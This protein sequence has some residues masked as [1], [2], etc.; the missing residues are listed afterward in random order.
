MG[1]STTGFEGILVFNSDDFIINLGIQ[2]VRYKACADALN[3]MR[4]GNALR[5]YRRTCRLYSN[6]LHIGILGFQISAYTRKSTAGTYAGNKDINLAFGILP[7]FRTGRCSVGG[8][9]SRIGK[10]AGDKAVRSA[11]CQLLSFGNRTFHTL[12]TVSQ[13]QL[14]AI[15]L[16]QIAAFNAHGFRHSQNNFV[17]AGS[18]YG[19][20]TD[21]G[22]AAGGFNNSSPRLKNTLSLCIIN[23]CFGNSIFDAAGGIEIFQLAQNLCFQLV[24]SFVVFQLQQRSATNQISNA[25][26][27]C[28]N[29]SLLC[30][31]IISKL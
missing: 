4:T 15:S 11:F 20:Q 7:D 1:N 22:V 10:L 5:K 31:H 27:N 12:S 18:S 25:S 17:T 3:F 26:I 21:T 19:C 23:H 9:V 29:K 16:Q 13:Y 24:F 28:H 8:R 6:N 30:F 14:C 2:S